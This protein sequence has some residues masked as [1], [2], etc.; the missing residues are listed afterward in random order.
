MAA[1]FVKV[2]LIWLELFHFLLQLWSPNLL[3]RVSPKTLSVWRQIKGW[4]RG[5]RELMHCGKTD[6]VRNLQ[7]SCLRAQMCVDYSLAPLQTV[8]LLFVDLAHC[9]EK[10][11]AMATPWV[12]LAFWF[13]EI[14]CWP[15]LSHQLCGES[16]TDTSQFLSQLSLYLV[17]S[18]C[19]SFF[20]LCLYWSKQCSHLSRK[21]T[22]DR[23]HLSWTADA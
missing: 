19:Q 8:T 11:S 5:G 15:V 7:W 17:S 21:A 20:F 23:G 18:H 12:Q 16:Q 4:G 9:N 13:I 6:K 22:I 1:E 2:R 14:H 10:H 3:W